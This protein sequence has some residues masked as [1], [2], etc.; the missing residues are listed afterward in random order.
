MSHSSRVLHSQKGTYW[1]REVRIGHSVARITDISGLS[2]T[3]L[4][5]VS[6]ATV[7]VAAVRG[8]SIDLAGRYL[9]RAI[10]S[11]KTVPYGRPNELSQCCECYLQLSVLQALEVCNHR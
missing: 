4:G 8:S 7:T 3:F 9:S 5:V 6:V 11:D 1:Y 10:C 2:G